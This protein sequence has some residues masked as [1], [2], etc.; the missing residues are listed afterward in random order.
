MTGF[1]TA[2]NPSSSYVS[3]SNG[4]DSESEEDDGLTNF[5]RDIRN[6]PILQ[7]LNILFNVISEEVMEIGL[8]K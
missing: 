8:A 6:D 7:G 4:G 1:Y 2:S 3:N 5:T